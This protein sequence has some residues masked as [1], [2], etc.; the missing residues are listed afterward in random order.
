MARLARVVAP[1]VPRHI[2]QRY[3]EAVRNATPDDVWFGRREQILAR[4]K[5]LKIPTV[6]APRE[7]YR[8]MVNNQLKEESGTLRV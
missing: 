6:V 1:G 5:R 3:H 7:H 8:R 2:T 4:R